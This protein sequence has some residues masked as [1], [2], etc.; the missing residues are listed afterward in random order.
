MAFAFTSAFEAKKIEVGEVRVG[1]EL[2]QGKRNS[3]RTVSFAHPK[4]SCCVCFDDGGLKMKCGHYICP[5]D[6]LN[7]TWHQIKVLKYQINCVCCTNNI[8]IADIITF[9]LPSEDEKQFLQAA[10][11]VNSC[12]SQDI[13]QCPN[14]KSYCKRPGTSA[15]QVQC[16]VC[17]R[18]K[19]KSFMLCWYCLKEW[20]TPGNTEICGN[21]DCTKSR[22]E[23]LE[24]SPTMEFRD[25]KGKVT[26]VPRER[27]CPKCLTI[28][29]HIRG[30]NEMA[31]KYCRHIFCFICLTPT[32]EGKVICKTTSWN[33]TIGCTPAPRQTI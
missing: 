3:S 6:L 22:K 23:I 33:G 5:D 21:H 14:C 8:D 4:G 26:K 25:G 32:R 24:N 7:H 1:A 28:L 11:S 2:F 31:C 20:K 13:Q 19:G 18:K 9:G 10:I 29:H 15:S 27:A 16:I 12:V 17:T 30:C